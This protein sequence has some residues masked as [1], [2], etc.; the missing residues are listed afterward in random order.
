[1]HGLKGVFDATVAATTDVDLNTVRYYA[2]FFRD[3]DIV[4]NII[5]SNHFSTIVNIVD[6]T[7]AIDDLPTSSLPIHKAIN[8]GLQTIIQLIKEAPKDSTITLFSIQQALLCTTAAYLSDNTPNITFSDLVKGD[9]YSLF[10]KNKWL[11]VNKPLSRAVSTSSLYSDDYQTPSESDDEL[12]LT[13]SEKHNNLLWQTLLKYIDFHNNHQQ[14]EGTH[15]EELTTLLL[16]SGIF[17]HSPDLMK[18]LTSQENTFFKKLAMMFMAHV[19]NKNLS[20][21]SPTFKKIDQIQSEES[22][23]IKIIEYVSCCLSKEYLN[24]FTA[25]VKKFSIEDSSKRLA[26]CLLKILGKAPKNNY[27]VQIPNIEHYSKTC[28]NHLVKIILIACLTFSIIFSTMVSVVLYIACNL[29][30]LQVGIFFSTATFTSICIE[31][32]FAKAARYYIKKDLKSIS[33][34]LTTPKEDLS[35]PW[36]N[37]QQETSMQFQP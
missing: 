11:S 15:C 14:L 32:L 21:L 24:Y 3:I 33:A 29:T 5:S 2:K 8:Y 36:I 10:S 27:D 28:L 17:N 1:M 26:S 25:K 19:N 7:P 20:E 35:K 31:I 23:R 9:I 12:P 16:T 13:A 6:K 34:L 22:P 30:L 37:T 4:L 18:I